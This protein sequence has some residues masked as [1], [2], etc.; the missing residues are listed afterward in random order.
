M[1]PTDTKDMPQ[2]HLV[3]D[4]GFL[5]A[6]PHFTK[7]KLAVVN[8]PYGRVVAYEEFMPGNGFSESV[9]YTIVPGFYRGE[10]EAEDGAACFMEI[11]PVSEVRKTKILAALRD[12]GYDHKVAFWSHV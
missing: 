12:L 8:T 11:S 7:R 10:R 2:R 6:D 1:T 3:V 5:Y 4:R 9:C